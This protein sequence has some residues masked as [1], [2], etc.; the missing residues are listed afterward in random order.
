LIESAR[1]EFSEKGS[2]K[3][4]LRK[5]CAGAGVTT[6][7]LYFFFKDK[8]DLFAAIVEQPFDELKKLLHGHFAMEK[9]IPLPEMYEHI[10]GGHY[11]LSA[12]LIHHLYAN[13]DAFMLLLTKSQGTRFERCV[14]ETVDMIDKTYR[15]MAESM[16]RQLPDKQ[17]N[18]YMLHWLS[19]MIIDAFIHLLTH[20]PN[21]EKAVRIMSRIMNFYV[22]SWMCLAFD[23]ITKMT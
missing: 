9:E 10:D 23:D 1:A 2:T 21:E 18:P 7:A 5:I 8:E 13:Y 4:S 22:S 3:A 11:E 17:V 15:A 6:G 14:D 16:A 12:A 20:E 19:H